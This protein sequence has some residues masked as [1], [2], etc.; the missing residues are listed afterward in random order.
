ML[1]PFWL[2]ECMHIV[3]SMGQRILLLLAA[4]AVLECILAEIHGGRGD[5]V[6]AGVGGEACHFYGSLL[7]LHG[8][9]MGWLFLLGWVKG[10]AALGAWAHSAGLKKP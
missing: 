6:T 1:Q 4:G 7:L 10:P 3:H 9:P 2:T 5:R 8:Q